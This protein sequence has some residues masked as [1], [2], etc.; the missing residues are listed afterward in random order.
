MSDSALRT[1]YLTY[2]ALE[3]FKHKLQHS[4]AHH[5]PTPQTL[6]MP[7]QTTSRHLEPI[8]QPL[9]YIKGGESLGIIPV[10]LVS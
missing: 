10:L 9:L 7:C 6:I 1:K 8:L 5:Q 2:E 3:H 4:F